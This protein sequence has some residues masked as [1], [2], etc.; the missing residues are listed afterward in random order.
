MP[1]ESVKSENVP[2]GMD[3]HIAKI[4]RATWT[5]DH[6]TRRDYRQRSNTFIQLSVD[7]PWGS[8]TSIFQNCGECD[9][10]DWLSSMDADYIGKKL[11]GLS[12]REPD[13][14]KTLSGIRGHINELRAENVISVSEANSLRRRL[15]EEHIFDPR[16]CLRDQISALVSFAQS[17]EHLRGYGNPV[18]TRDTAKFT[19]FKRHAW[20]PFKDL[21]LAEFE[22]AQRCEA[23]IEQ[24]SMQLPS[25]D[26]D[27]VMV[28]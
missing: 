6:G 27:P 25:G 23:E 1:L 4:R 17:N 7:C 16:K 24:Q 19:G 18:Q 28:P 5:I 12:T 22:R 2:E 9:W 3:R 15:R 11:F 8:G 10:R 14:R 20:E 26:E 21:M 13:H